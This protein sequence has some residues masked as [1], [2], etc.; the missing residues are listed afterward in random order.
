MVHLGVDYVPDCR[1]ATPCARRQRPS[2]SKFSLASI[3]AP[4]RPAI[5]PSPDQASHHAEAREWF[6]AEGGDDW[7]AWR[8]RANTSERK[9]ALGD[10]MIAAAET[11]LPGL[12]GHIVYR[13]RGEPGDL[14]ALRSGERRR[15]LRR[16]A[17]RAGSAAPRA[18]SPASSSREAPPTGPASKPSSSPARSPPRRWFPGC[19]RGR[20]RRRRASR[21][22]PRSRRRRRSAPPARGRGGPLFAPG[23]MIS[24]RSHLSSPSPLFAL[25]PLDRR[26][27]T[28]LSL[29]GG[30]PLKRRPFAPPATIRGETDEDFLLLVPC[31]VALWAPLYNRQPGTVRRSLL[32]LVPAAAHPRLRADIYVADRLGKA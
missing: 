28:S 19:W 23:L 5:R 18:R 3:P 14:R 22:R 12:S 26:P 8:L 24:R 2:A 9:R 1:P 27:R 30:P 11:V 7:K 15:D 25:S 31:L 10:R 4:R 6:P 29:G 20:A 16:G 21:R 13:S 32:L 17:L